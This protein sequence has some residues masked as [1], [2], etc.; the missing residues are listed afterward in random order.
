MRRFERGKQ[1]KTRRNIV[2]TAGVRFPSE[3][4]LRNRAWADLMGKC[5]PDGTAGSTGNFDSKGP[6]SCPKAS[7]GRVSRPKSG[8]MEA[9]ASAAKGRKALEAIAND[10]LSPRAQE[11]PGPHGC[12]LAALGSETREGSEKNRHGPRPPRGSSR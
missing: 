9:S 6:A 7:A 1:R 10:Y 5:R 2:K 3:W 12:P 4:D 11:G 8:E